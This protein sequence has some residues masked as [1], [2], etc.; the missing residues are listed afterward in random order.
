MILE[1]SEK[2]LNI[3]KENPGLG[4]KQIADIYGVDFRSASINNGL[5]LLRRMGLVNYM[6]YRGKTYTI[7]DKGIK[8]LCLL[9]ELNELCKVVV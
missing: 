1:S 3:I 5:G 7:N 6:E 8:A 2:L 4:R 9:T